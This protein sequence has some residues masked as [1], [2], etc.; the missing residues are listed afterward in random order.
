MNFQEILLIV[1]VP[2]TIVLMIAAIKAFNVLKKKG[3]ISKV[4]YLLGIF[5]AIFQP[6]AAFIISRI[7]KNWDKA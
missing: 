5:F 6:L 4:N 2:I 7:L 3:K 1:F